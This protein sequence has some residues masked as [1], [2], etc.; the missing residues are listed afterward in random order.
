MLFRSAGV[1][2]LEKGTQNGVTADSAGHYSITVKS[3]PVSLVFSLL[4]YEKR[5]IKITRDSVLNVLMTMS[6]KSINE[7]VV[8]AYGEATRKDLTSAV[9]T[10]DAKQ[11]ENIPMVSIDQVLQGQVAGLQ[12][13]TYSGQPGGEVQVRLRG[14]GS[15]TAGSQP[16]YV[17]DGIPINSG[18]ISSGITWTSNS[19]AGIN[20]NDIENVTVLKDAAA[21][22]IYGSRGANGVIVITTKKGKAGKT[23][24]RFEIGRAHV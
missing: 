3:Q 15:I 14:V 11:I 16:L 23:K 8:V 4:G 20:A 22:A 18:N 19:L 12:V 5:E 7:V 24:I 9:T 2:V 21:T 10:V 17:V 6:M 1:T 13:S